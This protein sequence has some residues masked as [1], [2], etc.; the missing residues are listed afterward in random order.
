MQR[1]PRIFVLG[2][3]VMDLIAT[4]ERIPRSAQTVYGKSFHM[5]PGGKG[6]NQAL[7][8]ARLGADVTMMGCVGDDL[9]GEKL[10]ETPRAAGVDVSHVVV[11]PGITSG[12]GHVTMEVTEHTA[13]NRII[14]IPGANRTLTVE[15]AAWVKDEIGTYDMVLLQL[16]VPLEVNLAVARWAREAGVPVMLNPAPAAELDDELL[17]LVTYLTPNEQ[18]ASVETGL[19]LAADENGPSRDDL[20]K[21]AAALWAK[22]VENVIITLGGAGS[23]V[24]GDDSIRYIPCVHMDHVADPTAAGDSFVG[25]LSVGLTVGLSQDQA[26]AFASHTAAITVSRMG[27][28]PSLPTLAEVIALLKERDYRGFDLS[29]LDALQ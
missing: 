5:A 24:V 12:V 20:Q 25:A 19:P 14:V 26:L 27:A 8:C 3:F 23:A 15:E 11:R 18:E 4:T 13:Q 17:S 9:F 7:Q 28:M 6:A 21:I 16:E 29:V 22:G 1:R 10:L 2:S